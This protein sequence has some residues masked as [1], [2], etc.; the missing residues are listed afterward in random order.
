MLV[1]VRRRRHR[2]RPAAEKVADT[3][4]FTVVQDGARYII[5]TDD[6]EVH[7]D[8]AQRREDR[9]MKQNHT[10]RVFSSRQRS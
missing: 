8:L 5:T 10:P 1:E 9:R 3:R 4:T 6:G 2:H 7:V